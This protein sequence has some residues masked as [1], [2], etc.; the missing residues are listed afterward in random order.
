MY[1]DN[2]CCVCAVY[3]PKFPTGWLCAGCYAKHPELQPDASQWPGWAREC[4]RKEKKARR[5][6][7]RLARG[8]LDGALG[9]PITPGRWKAHSVENR[10]ITRDAASH[11]A[12]E[13]ARILRLYFG[14]QKN[15]AEIGR[16]LGMNQSKVSR[17]LD[18]AEIVQGLELVSAPYEFDALVD[19][20]GEKRV[21]A[22]YEYWRNSRR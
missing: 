22:V 19:R 15:Q 7:R 16:I 20:W 9:E 17:A 10:I 12:P 11:L 8:G 21:E 3:R 5:E 18:R 1:R 6:A 13:D 14:K 2:L 4:K